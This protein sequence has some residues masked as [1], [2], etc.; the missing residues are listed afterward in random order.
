[1]LRTLFIFPEGLTSTSS[2]PQ[3]RIS[4]LKHLDLQRTSLNFFLIISDEKFEEEVT[5][6]EKIRLGIQ[7]SHDDDEE[8][9]EIENLENVDQNDDYW[10]Y[11]DSERS[12]DVDER[13]EQEED[14]ARREWFGLEKEDDVDDD[15]EED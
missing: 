7:T 12:D 8:V 4:K 2:R 1:M 14:D 5:R 15:K 6:R 9:E 13:P 11:Q 3:D 10:E